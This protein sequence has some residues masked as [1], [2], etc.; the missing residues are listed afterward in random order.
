M[1]GSLALFPA[2]CGLLVQYSL[3]LPL[4]PP[5]LGLGFPSAR[6]VSPL[7]A[8]AGWAPAF[9]VGVRG[10][11]PGRDGEAEWRGGEVGPA[12]AQ[13]RLAPQLRG[14]CGGTPQGR[15]HGAPALEGLPRLPHRQLPGDGAAAGGPSDGAQ[16][17]AGGG[18][19][20]SAALQAWGLQV[21][22]A[23]LRRVSLPRG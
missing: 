10:G 15:G 22:W 2:Q 19:G 14:R 18:L 1:R 6:Q 20:G 17:Q 4:P 11:V 16:A 7:L 9:P 12:P 3:R 8:C 13:P 5:P 23:P 21:T